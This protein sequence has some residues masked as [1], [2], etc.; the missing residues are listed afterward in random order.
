MR[1]FGILLGAIGTI[2]AFFVNWILGFATIV[3]AIILLLVFKNPKR[4]KKCP[5]CAENIKAEAIVCRF[6]GA[7]VSQVIPEGKQF[8]GHMKGCRCKKCQEWGSKMTRG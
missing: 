1:T 2:F 7:D 5:K 4:F 3:L 8:P 6:C